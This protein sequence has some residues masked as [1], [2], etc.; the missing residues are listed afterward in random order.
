MV[1][2]VKGKNYTYSLTADFLALAQQYDQPR[3]WN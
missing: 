2:A 3:R 1:A